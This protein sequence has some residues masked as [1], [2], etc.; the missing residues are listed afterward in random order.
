MDK[1]PRIGRC[2][3]P[4]RY[5]IARRA[6]LVEARDLMQAHGIRH[7]PVLDGHAVVGMI[8]LGDLYAMEAMFARDPLE[9]RVEDAMSKDLCRVDPD[10][11][12]GEVAREMAERGIGSVVV[13]EA[14]R[15][16]GIFTATDACRVLGELLSG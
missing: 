6:T 11:P 16:V 9:A 12:L 8:T 10:R 4:A 3:S 14:G 7:L 5:S 13:E 15:L 1:T 2:M